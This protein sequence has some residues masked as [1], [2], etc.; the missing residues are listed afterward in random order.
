[1][2]ILVCVLALFGWVA[3]AEFSIKLKR[4][5]ETIERQVPRPKMDEALNQRAAKCILGEGVDLGQCKRD[6]QRY[7]EFLID[8]FKFN[9]SQNEFIRRLNHEMQEAKRMEEG[10]VVKSSM[11]PLKNLPFVPEG[12]PPVPGDG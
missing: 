11:G 7:T 6:I 8:T 3:T 5:L 10:L 4:G 1:M 2:K 9:W 12:R